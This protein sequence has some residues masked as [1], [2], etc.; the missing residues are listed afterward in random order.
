M[1]WPFKL[2]VEQLIELH[3]IQADALDDK[4][5][6]DFH[7]VYQLIDTKSS[8]LL[9]HVSLMIAVCTFF[10]SGANSSPVTNRFFI[11]EAFGYMAVAL[12]LLSCLGLS[13][14]NAPRN[15]AALKE[16]YAR[17]CRARA[18]AYL[19]AL[20]L[21]KVLTGLVLLTIAWRWMY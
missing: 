7:R 13:M 4:V 21:T 16:Y 18:R 6:R 17:S 20:F 15:M 10:Y 2:S 9:T 14:Y 1:Y 5:V 12:I 8:S 19:F 3:Q 11:G